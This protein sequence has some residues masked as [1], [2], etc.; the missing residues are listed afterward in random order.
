MECKDKYDYILTV[1]HEIT[2]AL[3]PDIDNEDATTAIAEYFNRNF[4]YLFML[5]QEKF[6][7]PPYRYGGSFGTLTRFFDTII[8]KKPEIR[9]PDV[10][11]LDK[12]TGT[13]KPV[14]DI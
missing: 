12:K 14:D 5:I 1:I 6:D 4:P 7:I 2:H 3:L 13:W 8:Y 9:N 11:V 10:Y